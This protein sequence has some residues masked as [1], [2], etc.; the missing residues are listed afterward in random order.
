MLEN[1]PK[2]I[3]VGSGNYISQLFFFWVFRLIYIVRKTKDIKEIQF[4][5]RKTETADANDK[6]L[7]KKW[8]EELQLAAEKNR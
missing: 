6:L 1:K 5:L 4:K 2:S 8:K 3:V 7:D